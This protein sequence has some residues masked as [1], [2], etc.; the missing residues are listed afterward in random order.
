MNVNLYDIEDYENKT[1]FRPQKNKAKTNPI[2]NT[3]KPIKG[4]G[5]KGIRNFFWLSVAGKGIFW[6][7]MR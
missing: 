4:V 1:A 5:K 3:H 6:S 2:S 7:L